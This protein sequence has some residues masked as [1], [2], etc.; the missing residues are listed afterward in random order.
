MNRLGRGLD[1]IEAS[2]RVEPREVTICV[3]GRDP[4]Y[5]PH[6]TRPV[7]EIQAMALD[8]IMGNGEIRVYE[9]AAARN[10][11]QPSLSE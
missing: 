8:L 3:S 5:C 4:I 1:E 6:Y 7:G 9:G 11:L 10:I 2:R